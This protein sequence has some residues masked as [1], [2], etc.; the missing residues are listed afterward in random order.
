MS[1]KAHRGLEVW[2]HSFLNLVLGGGDA[3]ASHTDHF[4]PG[5]IIIIITI[6]IIINGL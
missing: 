3:S 4:K 1:L 5:I 2:F 6:K